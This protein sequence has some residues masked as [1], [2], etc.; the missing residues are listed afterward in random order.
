MTQINLNNFLLFQLRPPVADA[1][2]IEDISAYIKDSN[3]DIE[4]YY[5]TGSY[6]LV[7]M[8]TEVAGATV[9][10][11]VS[12]LTEKVAMGGNKY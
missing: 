9:T 5:Q 4:Y 8:N 2:N 10:N 7:A 12:I 3:T 11:L 1:G 6:K